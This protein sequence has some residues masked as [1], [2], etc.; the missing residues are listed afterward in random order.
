MLLADLHSYKLALYVPLKTVNRFFE[1]YKIV[2]FPTRILNNTYAKF[3][4]GLEYFVVN[5]LQR[6]YFTMSDYEILKCNGKDVKICPA[7][8]AVY[9]MEVNT[10]ALSLY[11]QS[12][13][14]RRLQTYGVHSPSTQPNG[15]TRFQ[16]VLL[17]T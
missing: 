13:E 12:R 2:L 16:C 4:V 14:A 9:S 8:Q 15:A 10:C 6:T 17:C 3:E 5:L 1:L 11:F 7:S